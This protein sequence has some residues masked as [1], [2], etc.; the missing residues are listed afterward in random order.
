MDDPK[1]GEAAEP[2]DAARPAVAAG[3]GAADLDAR[4]AALARRLAEQRQRMPQLRDEPADRTSGMQGVAH[5]LKIA[6]EFVAGILVGVGIGYL[7]DQLAG[8]TPFGLIVFLMIGFAAGVLNVIRGVSGTTP[9][10]GRGP[11]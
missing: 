1:H 3:P 7:I 9:P 5:G 8:T 4:S 11:A 10:H 6:S 2:A